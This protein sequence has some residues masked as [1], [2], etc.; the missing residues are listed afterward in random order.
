MNSH[1]T[2]EKKV[3]DTY[4]HLAHAVETVGYR[5]NPIYL[6]R[7][8]VVDW[9]LM[10]TAGV[11]GKKVLNVG[12]FEPIDE[13]I[14]APSVAEWTAIASTTMSPTPPLAKRT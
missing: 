3:L 10:Q 11:V 14:W 13:V 7:K 5:H 8:A 6:A 4:D 9:D 12:C 1:S 2:E